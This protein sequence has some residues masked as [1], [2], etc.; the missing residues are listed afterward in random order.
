[1][2]LAGLQLAE[3]ITEAVLITSRKQI[4][5]TSLSVGYYELTTQ[6]Y[7]RYLATMIDSRV[8]LQKHVEHAAAKRSLENLG[9]TYAQRRRA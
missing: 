6:P 2:D 4:E 5:T 8:N 9:S 3:H 7:I 1:M